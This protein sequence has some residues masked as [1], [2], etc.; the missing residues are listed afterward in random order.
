VSKSCEETSSKLEESSNTID[1]VFLDPFSEV[2]DDVSAPTRVVQSR[3]A[4]RR[5]RKNCM[6]S[7]RSG[8][9]FLWME[10]NELDANSRL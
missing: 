8:E 3:V 9:C 5:E 6:L 10:L 1:S 7:M 2:L 4:T